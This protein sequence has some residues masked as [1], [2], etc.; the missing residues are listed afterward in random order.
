MRVV[1]IRSVQQ[2]ACGH[3]PFHSIFSRCESDHFVLH[4]KSDNL[5]RLTLSKL[6]NTWVNL[7][8][9]RK[10]K[11]EFYPLSLQGMELHHERPP[12]GPK[13]HSL[14]TRKTVEAARQPAGPVRPAPAQILALLSRHDR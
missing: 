6:Q 13:K 8:V 9:L 7:T 4:E 3:V 11:T 1:C 2:L 14:V 12:E 5:T 10:S